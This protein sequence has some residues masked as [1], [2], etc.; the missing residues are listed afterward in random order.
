[1]NK[2][3]LVLIFFIFSSISYSQ[4][5]N[6]VR[7]K[8]SIPAHFLRDWCISGSPNVLFNTPNGTQFAGGLKV[9]VFLGEK[10]SFDTDIVFGRDY[11][12]AGPGIIGI[13]LWLF[14][15]GPNGL[16]TNE[17]STFTGVLL[18]ISSMILSAEHLAYHIPVTNTL[19]ISPYVSMLRYKA[20][21]VYG[22]Y[23]NPDYAGEQFSFA[24][25]LELNK[26]IKRFVV[27]PYAEWNIG[28][29]DHLSGFNT[30]VYF[31]YYFRSR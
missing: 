7:N 6:Q 5:Q 14:F 8:D 22:D 11:F 2:H 15:L 25:G 13:P 4:K 21:Y 20:S 12:H 28:Y 26:Y 27:S 23:Y 10:F 29:K 3:L 31:G 18:A 30:G 17:E 16:S 1:M 24:L 19:E 9:R